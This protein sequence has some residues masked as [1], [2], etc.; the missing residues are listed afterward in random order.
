MESISVTKLQS[1]MALTRKMIELKAL[2][3]EGVVPALRSVGCHIVVYLL[4]LVFGII[5][6]L[7]Q[8]LKK[9][10]FIKC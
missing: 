7:Q 3:R 2:A 4:T 9:G 8:V 1:R 5:K 10:L 6:V